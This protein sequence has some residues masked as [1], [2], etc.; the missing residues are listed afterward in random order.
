MGA[1]PE[2]GGGSAPGP[3]SSPTASAGTVAQA[4]GRPPRR[5]DRVPDPTPFLLDF[6]PLEDA[7]QTRIAPFFDALR[8]GRL[9]TT[10]CE[11]D[12][13]LSWPPRVV[14]P[15]CRGEKLAWMELPRTGR[16]YAFSAVL[17]GAPLGMEQDVPFVVGLL[18]LDG[19][20]LRI[21][22]RITGA[23]YEDCRIG[24]AVELETFGLPDGR[25]FYRFRR[26]P[27]ATSTVGSGPSPRA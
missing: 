2:A 21:L 13:T 9:T 5:P 4:D 23:R 22:S 16:L 20:P 12:G 27:A 1:I 26:R 8:Q 7:K 15:A 17:G 6:F 18:D 14:C 10:R 19:V 25:V 24:D 3:A 11:E